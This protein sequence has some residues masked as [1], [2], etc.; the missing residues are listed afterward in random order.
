LFTFN[1][2][3]RP[4]ARVFVVVFVVS[5]HFKSKSKIVLVVL[6]GPFGSAVSFPLDL[7]L[8]R[9]VC[10]H[11]PLFALRCIAQSQHARVG[12]S[13]SRQSGSKRQVMVALFLPHTLQSVF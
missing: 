1:D 5:L 3:Q 2:Q 13:W 11:F 12:I 10:I 6:Y 7:F 8:S 4:D 9:F